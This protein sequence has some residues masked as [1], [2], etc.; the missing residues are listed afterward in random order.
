MIHLILLVPPESRLAT[1][2]PNKFTKTTDLLVKI[3]VLSKNCAI[4]EY[5]QNFRLALAQLLPTLLCLFNVWLPLL[6]TSRENH[7]K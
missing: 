3:F 5:L 1:A 7:P 6:C 2:F 4:E